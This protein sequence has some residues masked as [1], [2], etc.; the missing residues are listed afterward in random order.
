MTTAAKSPASTTATT[1]IIAILIFFFTA[2]FLPS[3][4]IDKIRYFLYN[5]INRS[6]LNGVDRVQNQSYELSGRRDLGER[7]RQGAAQCTRSCD[8]QDHP[9]PHDPSGH[10]RRDRGCNHQPPDRT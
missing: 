1:S 8:R 7:L 9:W 2:I 3:P 6:Q 5:N 10:P 4:P